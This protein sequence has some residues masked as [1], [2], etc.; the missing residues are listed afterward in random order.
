ME[1]AGRD[2]EGWRGA[3]RDGGGLGGMERDG[4]GL[5]GME[6]GWEGWR[7][8]GRDG[9]GLG[10][11]E[12]G[13]EGWSCVCFLAVESL[14]SG[15][16]RGGREGHSPTSQCF[17][18]ANGGVIPST[19]PCPFLLYD[20]LDFRG[21]GVV[22]V[23]DWTDRSRVGVGG[24]VG[25][26][27]TLNHTFATGFTACICVVLCVC[28]VCVLGVGVLSRVTSVMCTLLPGRILADKN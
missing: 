16:W 28:L 4:G 19:E 9:G 13:W 10:G 18:K 14:S 3:G 5:G 17:G 7:G 15:P 12:G 21:K 27:Y 26:T 8:A 24:G 25:Q 22:I 11:R 2:G 23:S 20:W 1:G 6:G